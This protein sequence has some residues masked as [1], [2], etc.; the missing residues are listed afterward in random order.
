MSI[1]IPVAHFKSAKM[2]EEQLL[3]DVEMCCLFKKYKLREMASNTYP[4]FKF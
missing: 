4:T 1:F 3:G 2:D